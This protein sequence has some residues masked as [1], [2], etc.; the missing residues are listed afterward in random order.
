MDAFS[1]AYC[2]VDTFFEMFMSTA[3]KAEQAG[4]AEETIRE[5]VW[6][7]SE[8]LISNLARIVSSAVYECFAALL[9]EIDGQLSLSTLSQRSKM[10]SDL[11]EEFKGT[12]ADSISTTNIVSSF[13]SQLK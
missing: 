1:E 2:Q 4:I 7:A 11:Q 9:E 10:S 5:V 8:A 6:M 12:N 13:L 3:R